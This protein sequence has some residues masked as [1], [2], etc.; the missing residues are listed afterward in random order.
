MKSCKKR[1]K[2]NDD[3]HQRGRERGR[4]TAGETKNGFLH[5]K[6]NK[7]WTGRKKGSRRKEDMYLP[8][9]EL[10][11]G[12]IVLQVCVKRGIESLT[13]VTGIVRERAKGIVLPGPQEIV[14]KMSTAVLV[15]LQGGVNGRAVL[16]VG[17]VQEMKE[18]SGGGIEGMRGEVE[19]KREIETTTEIGTG[20]DVAMKRI[21]GG[22]EM[23]VNK[24]ETPEAET[25]MEMEVE[26]GEE[27][28]PEKTV[29]GVVTVVIV[30][31]GGVVEVRDGEEEVIGIWTETVTLIVDK[32][33]TKAEIGKDGEAVEVNVAVIVIAIVIKVMVGGEEEEE[34]VIKTVRGEGGTGIGIEIV[35]KIENLVTVGGVEGEIG[36]VT[37]IETGG[38]ETVI[39]MDGEEEEEG[40]TGIVIV[41]VRVTGAGVMI[42]IVLREIVKGGIATSPHVLPTS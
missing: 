9:H 22:R 37:K 38:G 41:E 8:L 5:V 15:H 11:E 23:T 31:H 20:L 12:R 24:I 32:T 28:D 35:A 34:T 33:K 26:L 19:I 42:R 3:L 21:V 18:M 6:E 14:I 17:G 29:A 4:W 40:G 16:V 36:I 1:P 30:M 7:R 13:Y 39:V 25:V 2:E 10:L 27:I